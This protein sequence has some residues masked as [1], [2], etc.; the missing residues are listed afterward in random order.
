M[1]SRSSK[2]EEWAKDQTEINNR[3]VVILDAQKNW[4][5][6]YVEPPKAKGVPSGNKAML[7]SL[8]MWL[9]E[10]YPGQAL[11]TR[12]LA[13][14]WGSLRT[15][16]AS[17][18][19]DVKKIRNALWATTLYIRDH[20]GRTVTNGPGGIRC[21]T[22]VIDV[23][24]TELIKRT[25]RLKREA[26]N[27]ML[28]ARMVTDNPH[29][30]SQAIKDAPAGPDKEYMKKTYVYVTES[31]LPLVKTLNR[32]AVQEALEG[33]PVPPDEDDENGKGRQ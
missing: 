29:E 14:I 22:G 23:V 16:P 15:C 30:I 27:Y 25:A 17:N 7:I 2:V 4:R 13:Q 20:C 26:K 3:K 32:P 12:Q 28:T 21:T 8:L 19:N 10:R 18:T 1:G 6:N 11:T 9:H 24:Q 5:K 31:V 33:P